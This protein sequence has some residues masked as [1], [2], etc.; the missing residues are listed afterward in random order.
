DRPPH[1]RRPQ[2]QDA[3]SDDPGV[4]AGDWQEEVVLLPAPRCRSIT[5]GKRENG[6]VGTIR[7]TSRQ[8]G[9]V[10]K[11]EVPL[12]HF[13]RRP[14]CQPGPTSSTLHAGM[15]LELSKG[16]GWHYD[17]ITRPRKPKQR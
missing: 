4:G 14:A 9:K 5:L 1:R 8:S 17:T 12:S 15:L 16:V 6:K 7:V 10:G 3:G 11:W 2:P 13:P